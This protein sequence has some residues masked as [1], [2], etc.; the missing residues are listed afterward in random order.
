M[1]CR[2]CC[3]VRATV[4]GRRGGGCC[5]CCC[6]VVVVVA[7]A[8][9]V[10]VVVVAVAVAVAVAVVVVVVNSSPL[11]HPYEVAEVFN[12]SIPTLHVAKIC[13]RKVW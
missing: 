11:Q 1:C 3:R 2:S 4:C 9:A 6:G 12:P 10:A 5:C 8:V 13:G 7:V